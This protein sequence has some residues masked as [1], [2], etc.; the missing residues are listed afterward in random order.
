MRRFPVSL[1]TAAVILLGAVVAV[2]L[3]NGTGGD[4][5]AGAIAAPVSDGGATS[6]AS[7]SG[8]PTASR[9]ATAQILARPLFAKDR[10]PDVAAAADET[11]SAVSDLPRLA[12][13]VTVM[14]VKFAIFQPHD[15]GKPIVVGVGDTLDGR[16]IQ[17]IAI[18]EIVV[19]GPS[20]TERLHPM[21][22][23]ALEGTSPPVPGHPINAPHRRILT[24]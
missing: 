2:E 10:R 1:L 18:D 11:E 16:T 19:T 9:Q 3:W 14:N 8:M 24:P 22:D 15:G 6:V 23:P 12:G 7:L 21:P 17:A 20:G 5:D 4:S 13:I